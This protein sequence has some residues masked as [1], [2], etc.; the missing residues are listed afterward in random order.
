[1][2]WGIHFNYLPRRREESE[3]LKRGWKYSVGA[4]LLKRGLG[5]GEEGAGTF[6]DLIFSRFIIF[7]FRNYFTKLCYAFE[8][9]LFFSTTIIL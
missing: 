4:G 3:K 9:K 8:K 5:G 7:K 2:G 1:M 6:Q